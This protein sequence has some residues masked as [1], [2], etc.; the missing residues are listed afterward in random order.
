VFYPLSENIWLGAD[1]AGGLAA[2]NHRGSRLS[3]R[4]DILG[5]IHFATSLSPHWAPYLVGGVSE[6]VDARD[7]A[8]PYAVAGVG[9]EA[10]PT[11]QL[12]PALEL[13][14]GGGVRIGIVLRPGVPRGRGA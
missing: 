4:A 11:H 13:G 5:R 8:V 12:V 14:L 2:G 6:R 7:R 3:G 9:V 1:L 10:P